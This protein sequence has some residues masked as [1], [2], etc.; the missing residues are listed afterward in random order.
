MPDPFEAMRV[1]TTP[2]R[3]DPAFAAHLRGRLERALAVPRGEPMTDVHA[4][5]TAA[6]QATAYRLRHG[7]IA[8]ASWNVADVD[9]AARFFADVLGWTYGDDPADRRHVAGATPSHGL[10]EVAEPHTLFLCFAVDDAA[11]AVT[12]IRAAGGQ[13]AEPEETPHGLIAD[14]HDPLG[15]PF[16][17]VE[18]PPGPDG[19]ARPP[20]NGARQ[21]DI[22]YVTMEVVDSMVARDFYGMVLGWRFAP[23][24]QDDGFQVEGP[25]PMTGLAGG[26]GRAAVVPMYRVDDIAA[27]VERVRTGGGTATDPEA[28]PYGVT[29]DCADDQGNRF[30]LGELPT[31]ST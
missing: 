29:S 23:G 6:D 7:D 17:V 28:Q 18:V 5:P 9:R 10:F 12:A 19:R 3:P 21:G 20:A 16:A 15:T 22:S 2:V 24:S 27:A 30:Y 8:Y 26:A 1:P 11:G 31:P 4:S 25:V 13:A 14:C